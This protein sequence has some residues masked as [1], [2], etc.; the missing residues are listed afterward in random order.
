MSKYYYIEENNKIIGFDT[1][2][3]RLEQIIAMPQ[4]S[5]LEIK[6][7]ERPIV[8]FEFADTDEYK[9]KQVS[10]REKKFRSEFFEIPNVGWYRKVPRGYSS[11]VESINT[12]FNAVSVM[13]SLPVDYLTFYTKPDFNQDE[14]CTE[15]WLIANQFKNKAMTKEEFMQF[16]ANFVTAWNNLEHLQPETQIN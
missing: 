6:E 3:A 11:A 8:N 4:Y 14:Q 7:T 15:E 12:A 13:N 2:K 10:E 16:Y 9:Q 5:H 1:D